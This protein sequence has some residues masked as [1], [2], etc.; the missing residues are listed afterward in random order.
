L[1]QIIDL[2][3]TLPANRA[4]SREGDSGSQNGRRVQDSRAVTFITCVNDEE[5]Y[6]NCLRY[7]DALQ[8]PSGYTVQNIA[9]LGA[10]SMA[11]GYQRAMETSTAR[12]K[13]YLHQD[14]Y[15]VHRGVLSDLVSLFKRYP[16]LG[17]VGVEGATRLP[18]AVLYSVNNAL[19]CYGR[20]WTY[21]RP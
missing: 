16:R 2:R 17:M 19:H 12:Y 20:H 13:I 1:N 14:V 9:V 21:R 5:Q 6:E 18:K 8:V 4:A 11:E 15:L 10:S 7:V 3:H